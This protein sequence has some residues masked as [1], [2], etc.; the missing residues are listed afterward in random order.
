MT[1]CASS[2]EVAADVV[3][4]VEHDRAARAEHLEP[5]VTRGFAQRRSEHTGGAGRPLEHRDGVVLDR[6]PV[7]GP[8]S[9]SFDVRG[10][11]GD[12]DH[13]VDLVDGLV[14][15][16]TTTRHAPGGAPRPHREVLLGPEP[17][18][19]GDV[20]PRELADV[21]R[22]LQQRAIP[23]VK[24]ELEPDLKHA[25]S[26]AGMACERISL[27]GRGCDRLLAI[28]VETRVERV[29]NEGTMRSGRGR[30]DHRVDLATC[31]QRG[32]RAERGN[33]EVGAALAGRGLVDVAHR[34]Q[35][36]A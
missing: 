20:D 9:P 10:E 30:D 27:V 26:L 23:R 21:V 3:A 34:G 13:H 25:A 15:Q 33:A 18:G 31:V 32:R 35:R 4:V 29:A 5:F 24:T 11:S 14:H 22:G 28:D 12:G 36:C 16:H 6:G 17:V 1:V 7:P 8:A 2:C 19:R